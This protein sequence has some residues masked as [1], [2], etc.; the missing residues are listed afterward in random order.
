METDLGC[1]TYLHPLYQL[2]APRKKKFL[3]LLPQVLALLA[4]ENPPPFRGLS[5]VS[6]HPPPRRDNLQLANHVVS[7]KDVNV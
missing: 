3:Q 5:R 4:T 6:P 1:L 7:W 2:K